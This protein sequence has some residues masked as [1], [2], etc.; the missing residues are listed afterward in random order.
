MI[1]VFSIADV[2][3]E[4]GLVVVAH[5][6]GDG[7]K[8]G[9]GHGVECAKCVAH[10]V[11]ANP[12][13][14]GRIG[15]FIE[16]HTGIV[17]PAV[18][19]GGGAFAFAAWL[20]IGPQQVTIA[21][22]AGAGQRGPNAG[23]VIFEELVQA[24]AHP[25]HAGAF[26]LGG[27]GVGVANMENAALDIGPFNASFDDLADSQPGEKTEMQ[28]Q[29]EI[30]AIGGHGLQKSIPLRPGAIA[31]T[32][33]CNGFGDFQ[34]EDGRFE[35]KALF[36]GPGKEA[37]DGGNAGIDRGT[38]VGEAEV[39]H[40]VLQIGGGDIG[41]GATVAEEIEHQAQ[42][43]GGITRGFFGVLFAG[44]FLCQVAFDFAS[45]LAAP[46]LPV[47]L[48]HQSIVFF[49]GFSTLFCTQGDGCGAL[50][51]DH[52]RLIIPPIP[53][54]IESFKLHF[55]AEKRVAKTGSKI[56]ANFTQPGCNQGL[57]NRWEAEANAPFYFFDGLQL[58]D[59]KAVEGG[60]PVGIRTPN[61]L[62]RSQFCFVV[63]DARNSFALRGLRAFHFERV[64]IPGSN[65][66]ERG[67]V[68]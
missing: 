27:E 26:A 17:S 55:S 18:G 41:H 48:P 38:V 10:T 59:F 31:F 57:E 22:G 65:F 23:T 5:L 21:A 12:G 52:W 43:I 13:Q 32:T 54:L 15:D 33:G 9:I 3:I 42:G 50:P 47:I 19:L 64:A 7:G 67:P 34:G 36:F 24:R 39:G 28:D 51:V 11:K 37:G 8:R 68:E 58:P 14:P 49:D 61:L 20:F 30:G 44:E 62:I 46:P 40:P 53:L 6:A 2:I 4:R 25:N 60:T 63:T 66:S 45:D 35:N 16:R 29:L 1:S 56:K